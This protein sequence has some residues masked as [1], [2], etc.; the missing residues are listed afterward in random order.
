MLDDFSQD[1]AI[2]AT[3]NQNF[4]GV[5]MRHHGEMSDHLLVGVLIVLGALDD[6]V[7]DEDIAQVG[8]FEDQH[9]LI[10]TLL[11][12]KNLLDLESHGLARPHLVDLSEPAI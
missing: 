6:I 3:D 8:G 4:L 2:T 5:G 11:M 10:L 9:I 7:E 12:V 1:T